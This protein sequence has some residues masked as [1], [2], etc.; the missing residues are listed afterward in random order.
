MS[1]LRNGPSLEGFYAGYFTGR[2]GHG[3]AMFVF[4]QGRVVGSDLGGIT[5][6]GEYR[7]A[8][9]PGSV[10]IAAHVTLPP[11]AQLIQGG[12][13]SADGESYDIRVALPV[14][15]DSPFVRL[16]TPRGP[17]NLRLVKVRELH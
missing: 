10:E 15:P 6:D 9:D 14:H 12:T 1:D 8:D 11:G 7:S 5:Y 2:E 16:E 17:V 3:L 13:T 4:Q